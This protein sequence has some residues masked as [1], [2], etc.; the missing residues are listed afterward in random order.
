MADDIFTDLCRAACCGDDGC[1]LLDQG[2]CTAVANFT[3]TVLPILRR[4][5][6]PSEGMVA[7]GEGFMDMMAAG[8]NSLEGRRQEFRTGFQ[9]AIDHLIAEGERRG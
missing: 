6:V 8:D 9:A 4:L 5:R 7:H 2:K 3:N 1:E